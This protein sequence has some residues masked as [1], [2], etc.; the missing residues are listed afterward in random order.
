MSDFAETMAQM[1]RRRFGCGLKDLRRLSGGA[2]QELWRLVLDDGEGTVLVLRRTR[3]GAAQVS[4]TNPPMETEAEL[5]KLAREAGAPAPTVPHV[6]QPEDD[7]GHGFLMSFIEGETLGNRIVKDPALARPE[8]AAECGAVMAKI[9]SI[10]PARAPGLRTTTPAEVIDQWRNAYHLTNWPR[11]VISL[12][13]RW[14]DDHCPPPPERPCVVHG[15]FRNGNLIIGPDGVRAVLDWELAHIGDPMEDLGWICVN[16]WRFGVVDKPV[17]GFGSREDLW[18]GYE[19]AGGPPVNSQHALFWEV[20]GTMKWGVM[21]AGMVGS[22][23][24]PDPQIDRGVIARRA[25]ENEV[26][27]MRLM[28]S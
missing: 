22:F 11:P 4:T 8:L 18:A 28:A 26:D 17:G 24:G 1:T 19:A 7:L 3:G 15:D 27:L 25:S 12:A 13:F 16:A 20:L 14:L 23:R 6:L 10:D 5:L 21:C 9:H 2:T